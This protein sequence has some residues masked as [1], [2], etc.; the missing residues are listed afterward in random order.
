MVIYVLLPKNTN[1]VLILEKTVYL[2]INLLIRSWKMRF[3]LNFKLSSNSLC[4]QHLLTR[5][6]RSEPTPYDLDLCFLFLQTWVLKDFFCI[7]E[8]GSAALHPKKPQNPRCGVG[9]G[10]RS[11]GVKQQ[12]PKRCMKRVQDAKC[13]LQPQLFLPER[14]CRAHRDDFLS[15]L[16]IFFLLIFFFC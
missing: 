5:S 16:L 7:S 10:G 12:N 6:C 4:S 9:A 15:F 11:L 14:L 2:V 3:I 8:A 1:Y 13:S